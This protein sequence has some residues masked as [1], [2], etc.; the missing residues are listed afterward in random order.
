MHVVMTKFMSIIHL[1]FK[2]HSDEVTT[3]NTTAYFFGPLCIHS[4]HTALAILLHELIT[5]RD[6]LLVLPGWFTRN[7]MD[8]LV[9]SVHIL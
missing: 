1:I 3:R 5:V 9:H 2:V 8:D 7:N 4:V 6:G